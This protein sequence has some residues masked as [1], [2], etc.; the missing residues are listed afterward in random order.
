MG[1]HS[2][3]PAQSDC[4]GTGAKVKCVRVNDAAYRALLDR[5][6]VRRV[7][8]GCYCVKENKKRCTSLFKKKNKE[9]T[10]EYC[11]YY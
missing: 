9:K 7:Q 3:D 2:W 5:Y 11:T 10:I 6:R 1:K 8:I 4:Q